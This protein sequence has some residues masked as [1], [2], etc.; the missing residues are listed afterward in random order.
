MIDPWSNDPAEIETSVAVLPFAAPPDGWPIEGLDHRAAYARQVPAMLADWLD[1]AS[2]LFSNL[3]VFTTPLP[4]SHGAVVWVL[5]E[6][7]LETED[8]LAEGEELPDADMIVDGELA[9]RGGEL[10]IRVRVRYA[11]S[12]MIVE[13]FEARCEFRS[14]IVA[15]MLLARRIAKVLGGEMADLDAPQSHLAADSQTIDLYVLARDIEL[16]RQSGVDPGTGVS[17]AGLLGG[18]IAVSPRFSPAVDLLLGWVARAMSDDEVGDGEPADRVLLGLE[19]ATGNAEADPRLWTARGLL[20]ARRA[21]DGEHAVA[22]IN[23]ALDHGG[24]SVPLRIEISE[25]LVE[26]GRPREAKRHLLRAADDCPDDPTLIDRVGV[27]LGNVG[28]IDRA[29]QL[30]RRGAALAPW[31]GTFF[32]QLGRAAQDRGEFEEAWAYYASALLAADLPFHVFRY[33][34]N[35]A[36]RSEVPAFV[37]ER[38]ESLELSP[39]TPAEGWTELGE[40]CLAAGLTDRAIGFL[41]KAL[42]HSPSDELETRIK[43][44]LLE[45]RSPGMLSKVEQLTKTALRRDPRRAIAELDEAIRAEA[46]FWPAWHLKGVALRHAGAWE[47]AADA[48]EM[49]TKLAP[50]QA[51]VFRGLGHAR[52]RLGRT[53][54]AVEALRRAVVLDP[55]SA[56]VRV[57]LARALLET[58]REAE[59]RD[60]LGVALRID[61]TLAKARGLRRRFRWRA[62]S[63]WWKAWVERLHG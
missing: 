50:R 57:M 33:V 46:G 60:E 9:R 30:W 55:R 39:S 44:N 42:V 17:A 11:E 15:T 56:K 4:H 38:I 34:A 14:V 13:T 26:L 8:L 41:E 1:H 36:R 35:L 47:E 28:A 54:E 21:S 37:R 52:L 63:R 24:D 27:L 62:F 6:R 25:R 22:L 31:E 23:E 32:A 10:E 45:A 20:S 51:A 29:C 19:R 5:P 40:L 18:A 49:A 48:F 59:A 43:R 12:A 16:A 7:L 53:L 58:G 2:G 3:A 61:P